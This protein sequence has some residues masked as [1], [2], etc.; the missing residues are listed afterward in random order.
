MVESEQSDSSEG[1][2][3]FFPPGEPEN[4]KPQ[5]KAAIVGSDS[6]T[7][8]GIPVGNFRKRLTWKLTRGSPQRS[9]D[10]VGMETPD[11]KKYYQRAPRSN[12]GRFLYIE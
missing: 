11:V 3:E 8:L 2:L 4:Q 5:G 9:T 6:S 10:P 7:D 12:A 1:R